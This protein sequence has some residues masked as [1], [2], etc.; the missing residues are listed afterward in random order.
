M[1]LSRGPGQRVVDLA[2]LD[3]PRDQWAVLPGALQRREQGHQLA[4]LA[5]A[6][7]LPQ[8][9]A[10]GQVLDSLPSGELSGVGGEECEGS[11]RV[12]LVLGQVQ[13]DAPGQV[14]DRVTARQEALQSSLGLVCHVG[15]RLADLGP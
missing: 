1:G 14:P 13:A 15:Q 6:G 12:A 4:A 9:A 8:R 11:A 7:V 5:R 2:A 3:H 10:Q